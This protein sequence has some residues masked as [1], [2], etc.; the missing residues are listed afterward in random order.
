MSTEAHPSALVPD[1]YPQGFGQTFNGRREAVLSL[2]LT[3]Q[4]DVRSTTNTCGTGLC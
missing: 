1:F 4:G 3:G 2:R